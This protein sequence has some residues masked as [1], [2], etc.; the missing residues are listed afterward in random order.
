MLKHAIRSH[1]GS[2]PRPPEAKG[3]LPVKVTGQCVGE[4][5]TIK[6]LLIFLNQE[7]TTDFFILPMF[8]NSGKRSNWRVFQ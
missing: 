1:A 7:K 3:R 8:L 4:V 6:Y 5:R 2:G